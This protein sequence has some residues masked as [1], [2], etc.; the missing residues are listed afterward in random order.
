MSSSKINK[1][2]ELKLKNDVESTRQNEQ[3]CHTKSVMSTSHL[4]ILLVIVLIIF[5]P[6]RLEGIGS[7]LGKAI[8][9][10]KKGMADDATAKKE[11]DVKKPD[12]ENKA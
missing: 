5:G 12:S 9:G 10:F 8:Q 3:L 4:L 7:S 2:S 1:V 6:S 11:D